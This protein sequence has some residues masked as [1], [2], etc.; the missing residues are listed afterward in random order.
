MGW[1]KNH[2]V[3]ADSAGP[4]LYLINIILS[5]A[6]STLMHLSSLPQLLLGTLQ[7]LDLAITGM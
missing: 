2:S 1:A 4:A 6:G 7:L 5:P 3:L